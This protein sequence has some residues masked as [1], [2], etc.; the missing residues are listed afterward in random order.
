MV[1]TPGAK[2]AIYDG[3]VVCVDVCLWVCLCVPLCL[4]VYVSVDRPTLRQVTFI[5]SVDPTSCVCVF[6]CVHAVAYSDDPWAWA[7]YWIRSK[8]K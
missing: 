7:I 5:V 2:F 8:R 1:F 3:F 4:C 6:V